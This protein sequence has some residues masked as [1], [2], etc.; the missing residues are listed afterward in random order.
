MARGGV[1]F[2]VDADSVCVASEPR[3]AWGVGGILKIFAYLGTLSKMPPWY[4]AIFTVSQ[5]QWYLYFI[6]CG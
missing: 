3:E 6:M 5:N 1:G 4:F 2:H